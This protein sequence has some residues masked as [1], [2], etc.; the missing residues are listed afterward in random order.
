MNGANII[1]PSLTVLDP[2]QIK[3]VHEYSLQILATTGVRVDSAKA[4]QL[5][6]QAIGPKAVDGDRVSI[7]SKLVEWALQVAPSSVDVYDRNGS[8]V[9]SLPDRARFG[10]GVTVLYFQDPETDAVVQFDRQ[11]MLSSVRLGD[12]LSS[13]DVISTTGIIQ[14]VPP[15]ASD[16]YAT[17]EMTANT[18]KP[19]II[20]VSDESTFPAVLDLLEHLHGDLAARPSIIPYFN[21]ITPLVINT[22]T[23]DKMF[24]AIERRLPFIYSNYG[25]AGASTP[26]TPA[27]A[28]ALLNAELLAGLTLGQLIREGTAMILGTLPA[29]FDMK[30][31]K[32]FYD[33]KSYLI[34][35][36]CAEMMAHYRLPHAGTSGSGQGWGADLIAGGHQWLNHLISCM[37]KVGLAPF[38]GDNLGSLVFSPKIIVYADEIIRQARLFAE[39]FVLDDAAVGLEEV[40]E[41]GP[42][43]HFLMSNLTFKLCR[44]AYYSSAIFDRLTLDKWQ[45][46]DCP[47]VEDLLRA[48]TRQLMANCKPP[49]NHS[50]VV[51]KGEAFIKAFLARR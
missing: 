42:G 49:N 15:E 45:A 29:Y 11:H 46:R 9:F 33:P 16:L 26:I 31:S 27:G 37:G 3:Q 13:F 50:D 34:D 32:S 40:A 17:L 4:R 38:V 8:I 2:G 39:G 7:P 23:V 28:L 36:A 21:P 22:G 10:I 48:H 5:F 25:M 35:L 43:G 12:A 6:A 1:K 24:V 30:E 19:L 44:E 18:T 41:V 47:R 51:A 20:L 14:D